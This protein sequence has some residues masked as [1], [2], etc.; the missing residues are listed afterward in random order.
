MQ[1]RNGGFTFDPI[2]NIASD[3]VFSIRSDE[4]ATFP[5]ANGN[6]ELLNNTP[7]MLL[8]GGNFLLL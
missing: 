6:F 5:P 1:S 2:N 3:S 8:N 7:F 4:L